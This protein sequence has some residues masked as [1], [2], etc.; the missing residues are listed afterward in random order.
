MNLEIFRSASFKRD[1]KKSKK[2]N[3]DI[4]ALKKVIALLQTGKELPVKYRD[5][6]LTGEYKHYRECHI[7][8][9]WLLMYRIENYV[10]QLARLGTH[11]E[12]F[13]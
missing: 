3:Q 10:L 8:G 11:S 12:L 9:D 4:E 13:G 2:Q 1:F 7:E 6:K 5:H